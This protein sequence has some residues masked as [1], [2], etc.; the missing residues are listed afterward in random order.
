MPE[1]GHPVIAR[2]SA[3]AP[4]QGQQHK[5]TR[6][7]RSLGV[8]LPVRREI[9]SVSFQGE[10]PRSHGVEPVFSV[11]PPT[12]VMQPALPDD[13]AADEA[14]TRRFV[15]GRLLAAGLALILPLAGWLYAPWAQTGPI[16][17]GSRLLLGLPC[18][19]CG[20]TRGVCAAAR[21]HWGAATRFHPLA[22]PLT[23]G[24]L[25][26]GVT[27]VVELVRG[28]RYPWY[29]RFQSGGWIWSL[30]GVLLLIYAVRLVA[31]T[32]EGTLTRDDFRQGW[33]YQRL[34]PESAPAPR[35]STIPP[36]SL[37]P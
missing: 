17:C 35:R 16:V 21:L 34:Y 25:A 32:R 36:D 15:R 24:C 11:C 3:T 10:A 33:L 26:V 6:F 12:C 4:P 27:A 18:P 23:C 20:L 29:R 13:P 30:W 31:W 28:R 5:T 19:G 14:A 7:G 8:P 37:T 9:S 1:I 22:V 2:A